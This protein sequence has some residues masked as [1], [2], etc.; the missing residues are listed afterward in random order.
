MK[1]LFYNELCEIIKELLR[2]TKQLFY[3]ELC[4][5]IKELLR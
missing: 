5:I 4:E 3:N 1:Q 2:L